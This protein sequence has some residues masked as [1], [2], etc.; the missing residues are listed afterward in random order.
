MY[1]KKSSAKKILVVLLAAVLLIGVGV[2]GTLAWLIDF[3]DEVE[4]TFTVGNINIDLKETVNGV[5]SSAKTNRVENN[6]FKIIPGTEQPKDP[7]VIVAA[8]SEDCY[9]F[10][11]ITAVNTTVENLKY[12]V[13]STEI[14]N[15]VTF[16]EWLI[17][18]QEINGTKWQS[19]KDVPGVYYREYTGGEKVEYPVLKD[20][21]VT[22]PSTLA[23]AQIDALQN[24]IKE[25]YTDN[26]AEGLPSLTFKAYAVQMDYSEG[27]DGEFSPEQ[28]WN[29]AKGLNPDGTTPNP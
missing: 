12:T 3:T 19:L 1:A 11:E 25:T 29:V 4:N 16:V 10:V 5:D 14:I 18:N 24:Y 13:G 21:K 8:G 28:A 7:R 22:Y 2:G 15:N 17:D 27:V 23:K 26:P 6:T 20:N 9:V